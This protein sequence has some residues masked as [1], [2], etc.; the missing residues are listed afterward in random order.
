MT[1]DTKAFL[2]VFVPLTLLLTALLWLSLVVAACTPAR[3]ARQDRMVEI[4]GRIAQRVPAIVEKQIGPLVW[5]RD[6][7]C[8]WWQEGVI[9]LLVLVG[10]GDGLRR[11]IAARMK[12]GND[13]KD[14]A[15]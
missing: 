7:L 8:E 14:G 1:A 13:R 6:G 15:K 5:V 3:T 11:V 10:G 12:N 9:A 2:Q 4:D